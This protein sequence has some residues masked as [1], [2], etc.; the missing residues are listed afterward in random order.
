MVQ[1]QDQS[2]HS[3]VQSGAS[4]TSILEREAVHGYCM[5]FE[6]CMEMTRNCCNVRFEAWRVLLASRNKK[7]IVYY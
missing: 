5:I 1:D 3:H 4:V 2:N 7:T 6:F